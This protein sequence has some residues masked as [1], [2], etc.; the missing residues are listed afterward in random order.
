[1]VASCYLA[2]SQHQ[3]IG[4]LELRAAGMQEP[5]GSTWLLS[6]ASAEGTA[7]QPYIAV[8]TAADIAVALNTVCTAA[9]WGSLH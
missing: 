4:I 9:A 2:N 3:D 7:D 5:V 1:M 8:G 6:K